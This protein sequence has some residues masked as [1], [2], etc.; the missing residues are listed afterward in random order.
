MKKQEPSIPPKRLGW[1]R[2]TQKALA[3]DRLRRGLSSHIGEDLKRRLP[4][5]SQG[6]DVVSDALST[7]GGRGGW[8]RKSFL[9][10]VI[11]P[12]IVYLFYAAL[13]QSD[14]YVAES[15]LTVREAQKKEQP[16][17]GD[18]ASVIAK[19]TGG[20]GGGGKDTQNTFMVLNYIKSRAV[21]VDLGGRPYLERKFSQ[22]GV[23]YFSRL[24]KDANLEE[25]WKY[26]L[27]HISASVDTISGIL[28]FRVDAFQPQD[29]LDLA[30]DIVRLSEDLVNKITLRN[31]SDALSRADNEVGLARQKLADARERLLQFRNQNFIIDPGSR[32]AS[33][34]E[35]IVKLTLE[36][37]DLV[38]ALSTFS[39][40]LSSDA[41][42]QRLQRT[43]LAAID[44]QIADL[45][46]KLTDNQAGDVVSA[47]IAS[48]EK[49]KLEEQFAERLYT[50]AQSAYE[51]ARQD[52]ER[53]QLYLVTV[54]APTLPESAT[55]PRV[56]GD[57]LL[58]FCALLVIW[59]V[60]ALI[61]AS[62]QDQV[63]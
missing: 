7:I 51:S 60:I 54:V 56:F 63:T 13:W 12:T 61:A 6:V 49:L 62:V 27:D 37:I 3:P 30:K 18:A 53:Q 9:I 42:S 33:L 47:Q 59:A 46:K 4:A 24:S 19:M 52:L 36:R 23:D 29:A 25:L 58:L 20:A 5:L 55:Y 41:P 11:L 22:P 57:T 21:L 16:K 2:A 45:K 43:R 8:L 14:R 38:N 1:I 44:Q 10:V 50:I 28:V 17:L 31:R 34:S 39:S 35:M 48:Y 40:T 15:R 32:A 26:W